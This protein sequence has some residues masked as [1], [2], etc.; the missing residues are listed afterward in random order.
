MK[1]QEL[2]SPINFIGKDDNNKLVNP[3]QFVD[4]EDPEKRMYLVLYEGTDEEG[5]DLKSYEYIE[6]RTATFNFIKNMID[7]I[8]IC[9]SKVIAQNVKLIDAIT[10]YQFMKHIQENE[11]V[12]DIGS[13]DIDEYLVGD[14]EE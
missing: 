5:N 4:K 11:L 3:I 6:G 8:D 9:D 7:Y 2:T 14:L 12:K 1:Q 13:F 10:V